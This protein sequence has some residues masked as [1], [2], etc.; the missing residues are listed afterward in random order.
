MI[1]R[2]HFDKEIVDRFISLSI[3][4]KMDATFLQN[5]TPVDE[6]PIGMLNIDTLLVIFNFL[7]LYEKLIAMR[8]SKEWHLII[9]NHAWTVINFRDEGPNRK[10]EESSRRFRRFVSQN[11]QN[12]FEYREYGNEWQ[13]PINENDV[14]KFLTL[15]AGIGLQEI[16]LP[17]ASDEIMSYLR[18][19]CP[20]INTLGLRFEMM[21]VEEWS[22]VRVPKHDYGNLYQLLYFLPKLHRLDLTWPA[23]CIWHSIEWNGYE[24]IIQLIHKCKLGYISLHEVDLSFLSM[25]KKMSPV[26]LTNL[27]EMELNFKYGE[28]E[29]ADEILSSTVG[30]MTSLTRFKITG[31]RRHGQFLEIDGDRLLPSIAHLTH[32]KMLTLRRVRYSTEAFEIMIQGLPNLETLVLEGICVRSSLVKLININLEKIKSLVLL[33]HFLSRYSSESLQSLSYHPTLENLAVRQAY[34]EVSQTNWVERIY[35]M[36]VTLPKI[37]N[38]KLIGDNIVSYFSQASYPIIEGTDIEVILC[39]KSYLE[40]EAVILFSEI[41]KSEKVVIESLRNAVQKYKLERLEDYRG[42]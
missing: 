18:V 28:E 8:V 4:S 20:N 33:P 17:V 21:H 35:D 19:N 5:R 9:K 12:I 42:L 30:C 16:H 32:L 6:G 26:T 23:D 41:M 15:Y 38:V 24:Q 27:R 3:L 2:R 31:E 36:L 39:R 40:A 14:L 34:K 22:D 25:L 10:V 37:K 11:G 7:S 1:C 13:F 29:M